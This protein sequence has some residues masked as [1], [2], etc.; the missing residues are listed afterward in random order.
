MM[1]LGPVIIP[2]LPTE[3][4]PRLHYSVIA[5]VL[6]SLLTLGKALIVYVNSEHLQWITHHTQ[7]PAHYTLRTDPHQHTT[8]D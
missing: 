1:F 4:R 8:R 5:I 2:V 3:V 7:T 6:L